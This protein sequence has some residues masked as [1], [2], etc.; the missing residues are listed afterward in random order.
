MKDA[1]PGSY[2]MR[3]EIQDNF[4]Q[5]AVQYIYAQIHWADPYIQ[6]AYS[7]RIIRSRDWDDLRADDAISL[8]ELIKMVI[9]ANDIQ[10]YNKLI[11]TEIYPDL[12]KTSW[13]SKYMV[14]ADIHNIWRKGTL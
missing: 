13:Y 8:A 2:P 1:L 7:Q 5:K 14:T 3:V 10:K 9:E 4:D 11:D 6:E 12:P